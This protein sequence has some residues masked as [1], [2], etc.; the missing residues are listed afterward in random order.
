MKTLKQFFWLLA[1]LTVL[2][3]VGV[4]SSLGLAAVLVLWMGLCLLWK[5]GI[6]PVLLFV[7]FYQWLQ[8]SVGV[9][10]ANYEGVAVSSLSIPSEQVSQAIFLSLIALSFL[11]SGM[12]LGLG[13]GGSINLGMLRAQ[14]SEKPTS[15]W[16]RIFLAAWI[17]ATLAPIGSIVLPGL[18]QVFLAVTRL[19]WAFFW[20]FTYAT[21]TQAN[22]PRTLWWVVFFVELI[23]SFGGFFSDFKTILIVTILALAPISIRIRPARL[24]GLI[25]LVVFTLYLGVIWTAVK[26]EYRVFL[27]KGLNAQVVLVGVEER[28]SYLKNAIKNID[29]PAM[30]DAFGSM[31]D[32]IFYVGFFARVLGY[33]PA[34]LPHEYGA[35]WGGA[36][37]RPFMPRIVFSNKSVIDDS[38][39]TTKYTGENS[40]GLNDQAT[41]VSIGY[42]GESYIDFG[43][44]LMM[45]PIFLLGFVYGKFYEWMCNYPNVRGVIGMG[46]ATSVLLPA[47]FL[48]TSITK[49]IGGLVVSALVAWIFARWGMHYL[50]RFEK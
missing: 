39:F 35:V 43:A 45:A 17:I 24:I 44:Y 21:F 15:Y 14:I 30:G 19:K 50:R 20:V 48:E 49:L 40:I 12:Y 27:N 18:S 1:P 41:S 37:L 29:P 38:E 31:I 10:K 25:G 46:L 3:V 13:K 26:D 8:A 42:I 9:F 6:S 4:N 11:A 7:F 28:Y 2:G 32:R 16:F 36:V 34:I 5:K 33:V 47:S 22:A 23:L